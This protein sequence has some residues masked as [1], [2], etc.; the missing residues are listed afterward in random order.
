VTEDSADRQV[1]FWDDWNV[2]WRFRDGLDP[3]MARQADILRM[4]VAG[5]GADRP[6]VLDVGCGTGWLT[7]PLAHGA[8][9]IGTDLS[10]EAIAEGARRFPASDL[11]C[12]D[13]TAVDLPSGFDLVVSSDSLLPM[14]DHTAAIA[15]IASLQP[16]GAV[17]LLMT[18]NP[19]IWRRRSAL[20][21][22]DASVPHGAVEEWPTRR[23]VR[24]LLEPFYVIE[25]FFTF[26]PGGDSGV[27]WWVENRVVRKAMGT[28]L[29]RDRWA[30]SLERAGLGREMVFIGRRR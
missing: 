18:Q 1:R 20:R 30:R 13:F 25:Q 12:A 11:R 7:A 19:S 26:G 6:R 5:I 16:V 22:H 17:L 28:V 14:P 3:F 23:Q 9:V 24:A 4:V 10:P 8:D 27:L 15:R 2:Q 29:G 21:P